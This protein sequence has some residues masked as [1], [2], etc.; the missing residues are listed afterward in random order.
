MPEYSCWLGN[1]WSLIRV[2]RGGET[3]LLNRW[4]Y[5]LTEALE[6]LVHKPSV[7]GCHV[8]HVFP[9]SGKGKQCLGFSVVFWTASPWPC[10]DSPFSFVF[11]SIF[12]PALTTPIGE[13]MATLEA[14]CCGNTWL[15]ADAL[16]QN[17]GIIERLRLEET[18]RIIQLQPPAMA[19]AAN[20][21]LGRFA[22]SSSRLAL[23]KCFCLPP[24][25]KGKKIIKTEPGSPF[26]WPY[27]KGNC[28]DGSLQ[29]PVLA[30][31]QWH[32]VVNCLKAAKE[33]HEVLLLCISTV[34]SRS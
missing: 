18:S 3:F 25:W 27:W 20:Q 30:V 9:F 17:H 16:S 8:W 4:Y 13:W 19:R 32:L 23:N 1:L 10:I 24:C 34:G 33:M 5:W 12:L 11:S 26:A 22:E 29:L 2:Y 14:N 28:A 31:S 21:A 15:R 7:C 6:S